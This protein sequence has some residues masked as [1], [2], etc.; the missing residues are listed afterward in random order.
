MAYEVVLI[1][2]ES[3]QEFVCE[4]MLPGS[5]EGTL[6]FGQVRDT[7][8]TTYNKIVFPARGDVLNF[9]EIKE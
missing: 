3:T 2:G 1:R 4:T 8:G 9:R 5:I 7:D 6:A